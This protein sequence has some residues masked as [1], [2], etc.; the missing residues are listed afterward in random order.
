VKKGLIPEEKRGAPGRAVA[1]K[2]CLIEWLLGPELRESE[3]VRV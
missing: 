2:F 1:W 3:W